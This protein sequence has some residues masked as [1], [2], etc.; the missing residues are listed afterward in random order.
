MLPTSYL[1][2]T[3]ETY[4]LALRNNLKKIG[5]SVYQERPESIEI[6]GSRFQSVHTILPVGPGSQYQSYYIRLKEN[7]V[8]TITATHSRQDRG[9]ALF[10]IIQSLDLQ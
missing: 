8:L 5:Y 3:T 9:D 1:G 10:K 2:M 6:S 7:E 4:A